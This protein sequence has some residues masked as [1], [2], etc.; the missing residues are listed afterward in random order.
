MVSIEQLI[1]HISDSVVGMDIILINSKL[2]LL[3]ISYIHVL[4]YQWKQ[5]SKQKTSNNNNNNGSNLLAYLSILTT[6]YWNPKLCHQNH[7]NAKMILKYFP[8][9]L[10]MYHKW[11]VIYSY[12]KL[13]IVNSLERLFCK[14]PIT[15]P[16]CPTVPHTPCFDNL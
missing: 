15:P 5:R 3:I 6:T 11:F 7:K 9:A 12:S 13:C 10:K 1:W 16:K 4:N 2:N 8:T 14:C